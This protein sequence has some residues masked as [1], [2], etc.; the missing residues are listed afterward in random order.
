MKFDLDLARLS[1]FLASR[2]RGSCYCG[3]DWLVKIICADDFVRRSPR[4]EPRWKLAR[5]FLSKTL[6]SVPGGCR[7]GV[8]RKRGRRDMVYAQH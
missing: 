2:V 6:A 7:R 8:E 1:A 5:S 4:R 3:S